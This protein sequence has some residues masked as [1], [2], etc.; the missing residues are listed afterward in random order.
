MR[1]VNR[2]ALLTCA[3]V[4]GLLVVSGS[5]LWSLRDQL[6]DAENRRV[7]DVVD[8][9]YAVLEHFHRLE[10]TGKLSQPEAQHLALELLRQVR[11]ENGKNYVFVSDDSGVVLLSPLRPETEGINMIGKQSA[12]GVL[13][14]DHIT[15]VAR[16]GIPQII[17]YGWPRS[18]GAPSEEKYSHVKP[19]PP[20]RWAYGAGIY[21]T[22][23]NEAFA[24]R[25]ERTLFIAAL[26][27]LLFIGISWLIVRSVVHQLGGDPQEAVDAMHA[28]ATGDF[29]FNANNRGT[30]SSLLGTLADTAGQLQT[31]Q[32][33]VDS[34]TLEL[35]RANET[36]ARLLEQLIATQ[37]QLVQTEKLA[38]L[39]TLVAG[40][41][42]ELGTPI[43]NCVLAAS[44][45]DSLRVK[46]QSDLESGLRKSTLMSFLERL[47]TGFEAIL[48]NLERTS[49][50]VARFKE[51]SV[52]P[53]ETVRESFRLHDLINEV[54]SAFSPSCQKAGIA[55][56]CDVPRDL[57]MDSYP[58]SLVQLLENLT[59]NA[60][61]HAFE[62]Y[63]E[64]QISISAQESP[65]ET[66]LIVF[67]DNG[68]G[69]SG[70]NLP[71]IFDPF[72]T[73][74]MGRGGTGLGLNIAYSLVNAALGGVIRVESEVGQGTQF[75]IALPKT[76]PV[77]MIKT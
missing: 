75:Y 73:T 3:A 33:K 20:W 66:I 34:R 37:T 26:V 48:R 32:A 12:D 35:E 15:E 8:S 18:A 46:L 31:M 71:K 77:R 53:T 39:G 40:V 9:M 14:W 19:Y 36:Q 52:E 60:L 7:S 29:S 63:K 76:A 58:G 61:Q 62:G 67:A 41:A 49:L 25:L 5:S 38:S 13:L 64:G 43:G 27:L 72:F 10:L 68:G 65:D 24:M 4:I 22:A 28:I 47:A 21:L 55:V 59:T 2:L 44:T 51:I 57:L 70:E 74:Q 69:I 17:H 54:R 30:G 56:I 16:T 23:V 11:Y 45:L 42:H 1:L 50:L 6:V